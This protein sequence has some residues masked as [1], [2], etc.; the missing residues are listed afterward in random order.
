MPAFSSGVRCASPMT[1]R[2]GRRVEPRPSALSSIDPPAESGGAAEWRRHAAAV[3][4]YRWWI[5]GLT[6]LGTIGGAGASRVLPPRYLVQATI[7]I[8]SSEARGTPDRGP[9]GANQLLAPTAWGDLL[10]SYVV[11]DAVARERRLYLQAR[12]RDVPAL[13]GFAVGDQF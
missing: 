7:W 13:A 6:V 1:S 12:P 8:Q 2:A 10:K 11:L 3:W 5:L 4:R 9:I